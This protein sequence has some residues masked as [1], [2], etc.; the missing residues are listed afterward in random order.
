M[1][2]AEEL[3]WI[4]DQLWFSITMMNT[5]WIGGQAPLQLVGVGDGAAVGDAVGVPDG[6]AGAHPAA[7]QASQQLA[8][9]PTHA[10]PPGGGEQRLASR[11]ILQRVAPAA[12]VRQQDTA[13]GLPHVDRAAH[14]C[15]TPLQR[16]FS[17]P[18]A[19]R[20]LRTPAEQRT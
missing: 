17:N 7:A 5:V 14:F 12:V 2:G 13:P 1:Y 18:F 20:V 19:M 11:L 16:G 4:L 9:L 15:T 8:K 6:V 3:L 10:V